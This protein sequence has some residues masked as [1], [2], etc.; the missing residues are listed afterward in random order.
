LLERRRFGEAS[1]SG[2]QRA[3]LAA[4]VLSELPGQVK[5]YMKALKEKA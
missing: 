2:D 4:S 3:A 5:D 1:D